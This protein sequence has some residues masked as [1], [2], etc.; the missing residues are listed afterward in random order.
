MPNRNRSSWLTNASSDLINMQTL[1]W[2]PDYFCH[3]YQVTTQNKNKKEIQILIA[4]LLGSSDRDGQWERIPQPV[5][6]QGVS[7]PGWAGVGCSKVKN[8]EVIFGLAKIYSPNNNLCTDLIEWAL[9]PKQCGQRNRQLGGG[10]PLP[11]PPVPHLDILMVQIIF[12]PF[13]FATPLI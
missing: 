7:V 5:L 8:S 2:R 4:C 11:P 10:G 1:L 9:L 3:K 12:H 13:N 6:Q